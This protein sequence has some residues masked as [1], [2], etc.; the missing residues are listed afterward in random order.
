MRGVVRLGAGAGVEAGAGCAGVSPY[1]SPV[2]TARARAGEDLHSQAGLHTLNSNSKIRMTR[3]QTAQQKRETIL[4]TSQQALQSFH[5]CQCGAKAQ[6]TDRPPWIL[7]NLVDF[8]S[9]ENLVFTMTAALII[10]TPHR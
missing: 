3:H 8:H 9:A 4:T 2:I 6:T 1:L 5:L 10:I 7:F